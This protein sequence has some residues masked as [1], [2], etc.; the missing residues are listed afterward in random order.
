M[1]SW[2]LKISLY[3]RDERLNKWF[4]GEEMSEN[5]LIFAD[6]HY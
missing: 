3:Q 6:N 5:L 4:R 2:F 1:Q